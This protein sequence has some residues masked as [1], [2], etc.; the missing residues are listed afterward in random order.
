MLYI[1]T[2][3]FQATKLSMMKMVMPCGLEDLNR[4]QTIIQQ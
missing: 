3:F 1:F 4:Y 2:N